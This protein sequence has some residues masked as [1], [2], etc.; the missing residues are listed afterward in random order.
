MLSPKPAK[1]GLPV[2]RRMPK[3]RY[4]FL[5]DIMLY[6]PEI[7]HLRVSRSFRADIVI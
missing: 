1:N 3:S 4:G 5:A 2:S 6:H 7:D